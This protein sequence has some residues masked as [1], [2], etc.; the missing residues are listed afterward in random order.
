MLAGFVRLLRSALNRL[1]AGPQIVQNIYGVF[2]LGF[3]FPS[4]FF[5]M[6]EG[7]RKVVR[8]G[9][10]RRF[11]VAGD[12]FSRADAVQ[13]LLL[14]RTRGAEGVASS[15]GAAALQPPAVRVPRPA[16]APGPE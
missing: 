1:E 16:A 12:C 3:I 4:F 10:R 5:R 7:A 9:L 11:S 14:E 13:E 2:S 15:R 6:T 8:G